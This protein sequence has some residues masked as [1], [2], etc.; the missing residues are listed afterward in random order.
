MISN[1]QFTGKVNQLEKSEKKF[2]ALSNEHTQLLENLSSVVMELDET[3]HIRFLKNAWKTLT[4][5]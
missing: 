2:K 1:K 4:G 5:F 3:G